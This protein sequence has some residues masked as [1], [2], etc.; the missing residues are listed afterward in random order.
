MSPIQI[1]L[2]TIIVLIVLKTLQKYR[3]QSI[4]V[5]EFFLWT[6]FWLIGAV[7]V[8]FPN[9]IQTIANFVGIGRGVDLLIYLSLIVLFFGM[10]YVLVRLERIERDI[11]ALVR[12]KT[13]KEGN[14][15]S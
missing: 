11:T 6:A 3:A 14:Q 10:F 9:A 5:R 13:L 12:K 8:I 15:E 4:T 7:L 1:I 2:L